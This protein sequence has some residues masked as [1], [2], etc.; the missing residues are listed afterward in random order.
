M[1][2]YTTRALALLLLVPLCALGA[3]D[4]APQPVK[5]R[6]TGLFSVDRQDDLRAVVESLPG[7]KLMSIDFENAEAT[8]VYDANQ[9]LNRPNPQQQIERFDNLIRTNSHSTFGIKPLSALPPDKLQ[10]VEIPVFGLD[11]KGCALAAY[12]SLAN[13]PGVEQAT[14]NFKEGR[15]RAKV[16]P[17]KVTRAQ[18]EAALKQRGVALEPPSP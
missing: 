12:E 2:R 8:F 16:D 7:V 11:C 9:L 10:L 14:V 13:V 15:A 4:P 3:D 1:I 5:H 17:A 18:L 6:V